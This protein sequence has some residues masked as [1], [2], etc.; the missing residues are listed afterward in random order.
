MKALV[1]LQRKRDHPPQTRRGQLLKMSENLRSSGYSFW[2][3]PCNGSQVKK[4]PYRSAWVAQSIKHPTPVFGSD[5]VLGV[6]RSNPTS[7]SVLSVESA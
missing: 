7:G 5:H 4:Y 3:M 6:V 1:G 2:I